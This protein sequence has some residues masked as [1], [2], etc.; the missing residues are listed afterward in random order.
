MSSLWGK[1]CLNAGHQSSG[2]SSVLVFPAG[3]RPLGRHSPPYLEPLLL[4]R[5]PFLTP[6]AAGAVTTSLVATG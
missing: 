4:A 3:W 1:G 6:A 2:L 5:G